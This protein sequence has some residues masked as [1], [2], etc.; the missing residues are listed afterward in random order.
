MNDASARVGLIVVSAF[1]AAQTYFKNDS[2][3]PFSGLYNPIFFEVCWGLLAMLYP[4]FLTKVYFLKLAAP[5][6]GMR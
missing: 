5:F 1:A 4:L 6:N 3:D 2:R